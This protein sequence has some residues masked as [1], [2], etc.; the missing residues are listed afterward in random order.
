MSSPSETLAAKIIEKL[1]QEKLLSRQEARKILPK[2]A[3]GKLRPEDW[4]LSI[5]ISTAQKTQS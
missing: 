2:L 5:E 3:D 4:R 1:I